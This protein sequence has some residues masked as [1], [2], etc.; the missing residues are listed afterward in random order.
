[1]EE[2][3]LVFLIVLFLAGFGLFHIVELFSPKEE[4]TTIRQ[5]CKSRYDWR[6]EDDVPDDTGFFVIVPNYPMSTEEAEIYRQYSGSFP[7]P[8]QIYLPA[9]FEKQYVK[10]K[11]A[12][13]EAY[14]D[15]EDYPM[16]ILTFKDFC[17]DYI[18][19]DDEQIKY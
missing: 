8:E 6:W 15:F 12:F 9:D 3:P 1:M 2:H 11:A 18:L 17:N 13:G 7:D 10:E 16:E 5:A 4:T 14:E 19:S